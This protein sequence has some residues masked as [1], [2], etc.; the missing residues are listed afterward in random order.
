MARDER[1]PIEKHRAQ[2]GNASIY[3][4]TAGAGKPLLLVHGLAGSR[5]WWVKNVP[6]LAQ[7]FQLYML[8][9][10]GFGYS[11]T[12]QRFRLDEAAL[13]LVDWMDQL[14]LEQTSIIGHSMG[15]RIAA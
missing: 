8:D 6:A 1:V 4:E 3:Y 5:R 2:V 12:R 14:Q 10:I 9:L 7:H 13:C 11:R 15:G